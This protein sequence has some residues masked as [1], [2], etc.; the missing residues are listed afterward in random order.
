[1]EYLRGEINLTIFFCVFMDVLLKSLEAEV[2]GCQI[3]KHYFGTLSYAY[4]L[5][6]AV[7]SIL[8]LRKMLEICGKYGEEFNVD[9]NPTKTV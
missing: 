1:M 6:L 7:P 3:G 8:G 9:Y 2:F 4:D 5:T